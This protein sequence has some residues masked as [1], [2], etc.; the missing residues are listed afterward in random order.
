M[1]NLFLMTK[2]Q[3]QKTKFVL[4]KKLLSSVEKEQKRKREIEEKR[5]RDCVIT[6]ITTNDYH[7]PN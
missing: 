4:K 1:R 6:H 7:V 2:A 3:Q 5:K